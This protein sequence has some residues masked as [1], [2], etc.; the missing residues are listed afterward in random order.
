M[1]DTLSRIVQSVARAPDLDA[2]LTNIVRDVKAAMGV[3]VCSVYLVDLDANCHVLRASDGLEARAINQ[4]KIALGRGVVGLVTERAEV[5]NLD[6]AATHPSYE[7]IA[8]TGEQA[9]HGFLGVPIIQHRQVLGVLVVRQR[10]SRRFADDEVAFLFTLGAQLAGAITHAS[11]LDQLDAPHQPTGLQRSS[12]SGLAG[13]SGITIGTAMVAEAGSALERVPD[14]RTDDVDNEERRFRHA[15]AAV[16]NDLHRLG[17]RLERDL[18]AEDRALFDALMMMLDSDALVDD[19][20]ARIRDGFWAPAALRDTVNRHARVF[21]EM[22]DVYLRERASDVR[23]LGRRVLAH[24]QSESESLS[25]AARGYPERTILVGHD[26]TALHLAEVP[27][28][29][30]AGIVSLRGSGSS[31]AAILARA[32]GVPAVMGVEELPIEHIDG[33]TLIVNGYAGELHFEPSEQLRAEFELLEA[34]E[35]QIS[36]E[37]NTLRGQPSVTLDGRELPL[38]INAGLFMEA[39]S[40]DRKDANGVGL[41]RTELPFMTRDRFPSEETQTRIYRN[42]LEDMQ[43]KPVVM[44]TLDVGGDKPLSYFPVND[45]NPFLGWRGIRITLDHPEIFLTQVRAMLRADIGL[46]NL[47]IML[48]M[49]TT[50]TE[51]DEAMGLIERMITELREEGLAV[52]RPPIG[53]M[54]EVPAAVYQT[55][56][57]ARRVDFLSIGT[58]DLTQYLLAVDRNNQKVASIYDGLHP[59]VLRAVHD[60]IRRAHCLDCPVSVCGEMAGLPVGALLLLGMGVDSLS[61]GVGN[62]QRIKAVVRAVSLE[63]AQA[64]V[65]QVSKFE[66]GAQVRQT[67]AEAIENAGLGALVRAGR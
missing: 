45:P 44:R 12:F 57:L 55:E 13:S 47:M 19:T 6:D 8:D 1:L 65:E 7:F 63:Q 43:G 21:D 62:L 20:V 40:A 16:R 26:L 64:L 23:D 2:A 11:A 27:L 61:M 41:F 4:V 30:L 49:V 14:R 42:I 32:F 17:R 29:R 10:V 5:I 24:L 58:N 53:V 37:L 15:V 54:I 18:S 31:H 34:E 35:Q 22:D 51:V 56:S 36:A 38:M 50:V 9:L 52:E 3:D 66:H 59:A 67:L 48:P 39:G 60:V 33:R 25:A 46:G 28:E